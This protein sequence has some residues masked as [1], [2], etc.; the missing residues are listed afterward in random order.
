MRR[1]HA[2]P[3]PVAIALAL[4]LKVA[5]LVMLHKAFFSAPQAKHMRVPTDQVEQH[6][7]SAPPSLPAPKAKP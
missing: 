3:L 6:L 4:V 5:L 2:M 1:L 7:L